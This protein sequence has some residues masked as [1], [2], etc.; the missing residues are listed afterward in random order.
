MGKGYLMWSEK[1]MYQAF[2]GYKQIY[3]D[4]VTEG[5]LDGAHKIKGKLEM[6][7]EI[8]ASAELSSQLIALPHPV[9]I[10]FMN[11]VNYG[12]S[13]KTFQFFLDFICQ[14]ATMYR[15]YLS[16]DI[17]NKTWRTGECY[18]IRGDEE[19]KLEDSEAED[20]MAYFPVT[21]PLFVSAIKKADKQIETYLKMDRIELQDVDVDQHGK[22]YF[23]FKDQREIYAFQRDKKG[24]IEGFYCPEPK[25]GKLMLEQDYRWCRMLMYGF[26]HTD[27]Y[28]RLIS[29]P[30]VRLKTLFI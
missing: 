14:E 27:L 18:I 3:L 9:L 16:F 24:T 22:I 21:H 5:S 2:E 4:M 28:Q 12:E 25:T 30:S 8:S 10:D 13:E 23:K 26:D 7:C 20:I 1:L 15:I 29:H 17:E 11:P 6:L 19:E